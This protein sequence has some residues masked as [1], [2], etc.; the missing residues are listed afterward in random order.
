MIKRSMTFLIAVFLLFSISLTAYAEGEKRQLID[1]ANLV[2]SADDV[3]AMEAKLKNLSDTLQFDIAIMTVND[4]GGKSTR[5]YADDFYDY[6][7]YGYGADADG[8]ILVV[9]MSERYMWISTF[10]YGITA[11]TDW[12]IQY[13]IDEIKPA[14]SEGDYAGAFEKYADLVGKFVNEARQGNPYDTNHEPR[15]FSAQNLLIAFIAAVVIVGIIIGM[16]MKSYKPVRMQA[17]AGDYLIKDSLLLGM[18]TDN[19]L[20]SSVSKV[21]IESNSSSGS[22]GGGSST[23]TSSSGS[24]HGGGGGHF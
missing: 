13:I 14:M 7:G 1:E 2:S 21:S 8:C 24:T 23:H 12:G 10:G 11:L 20:Y 5:E 4:C 9:N 6:N 17:D 18:Q 3:A 15:Q 19:F 16:I 22:G